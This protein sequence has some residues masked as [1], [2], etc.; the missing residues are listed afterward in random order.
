MDGID[1][2]FAPTKARKLLGDLASRKISILELS[3]ECAYWSMSDECFRDLR[4]LPEPTRP[5]VLVDYDYE[6]F[7]R[8]EKLKQDPAFWKQP[9][10]FNYLEAKEKVKNHN[11]VCVLRLKEMKDLIPPDDI[12]AQQ[13]INARLAEFLGWL[14]PL[15]EK[16]F[17]NYQEREPG[18][19]DN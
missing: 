6:P 2:A 7:S 3:R 15:P 10:V 18:S 13:K 16:P 14:P 19:D 11:K 9:E 12:P 4:P 17:H 8:K 1:L 5:Q